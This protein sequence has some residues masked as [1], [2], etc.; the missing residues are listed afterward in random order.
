ME[1]RIRDDVKL[2]EWFCPIYNRKI[3]CGLCFDISNI[4]DDILCLKGDDKPPCSWDDAHKSC[5]KC[6]HYAAWAYQPNTA[7]VFAHPGRGAFF[8]PILPA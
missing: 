3:D 2:E 5:L 8:M 1:F 7:S 6:Q 4:G